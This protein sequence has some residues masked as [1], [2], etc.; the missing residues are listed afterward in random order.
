MPPIEQALRWLATRRHS[1]TPKLLAHAIEEPETASANVLEPLTAPTASLLGASPEVRALALWGLL[2]HEIDR[3]GSST[4]SRRRNVLLAAFRLSRPSTISEPWK[5][6]LDDRFRQLMQLSGVFG[7][8]RP[9]TTMPM[10]R[11][12]KNAVADKLTP[13]LQSRLAELADNG[14]R[15]ADYVKIAQVTEEIIANETNSPMGGY[16]LPS[17]GAQPVFLDLFVTTVFMRRK[18]VYRRI[19][20]RLVTAQEEDVDGYT[21]SALAGSTGNHASVPVA[22]LWGCHAE[23]VVDTPGDGPPLTRLRFPRAL[24]R[25]E[26]HYFSSEAIDEDI[27][28][29]RR[30]VNVEVDHHGIAPGSLLD[31]RIP[32][33]GLTI[34]IR[35]DD[36]CLPKVCWWYAEM[37][38]RQRG[39]Q[40]RVGSP[41]ILPIT[42]GG[43]EHTFADKCQPRENHGISI[44]WS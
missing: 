10:H 8:P 5:S 14:D 7:N 9:S 37:T 27:T 26:K 19:T 25:G 16:R 6:S 17:E 21:A 12:W 40:P 42:G 43:V 34:R 22:A 39:V 4:E 36:A 13:M 31:G 35:F 20:E 18:A 44:L 3:I 23:P 38:E 33:S 2:V 28:K 1:R 11:A 30:W 29:D 32:T 15:W 41:R 24:Q